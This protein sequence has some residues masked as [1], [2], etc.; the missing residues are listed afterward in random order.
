LSF[1]ARLVGATSPARTVTLTNTGT[2]IEISSIAIAG[3]N[4]ADFTHT[5]NCGATLMSGATCTISVIFKPSAI[6]KRSG[7]LSIQHTG[8]GSPH[9]V[10]LSGD[11][12]V[13]KL[14]PA[15]LNF[16]SQ[17][18]GTASAVQTS[19]LTNTGSTA[20]SISSIVTGGPHP[21]DFVMTHTCPTSLAAGSSCPIIIQFKPPL[22]PG[23]RNAAVS[24][25]H[26]GGG[27]PFTLALSGTGVA[28][29]GPFSFLPPQPG[30]LVEN[31]PYSLTVA[32][33][34]NDGHQ[35]AATA[36]FSSGVSIGLGGGNGG[37][38]LGPHVPT[39][40]APYTITAADFNGDNKVD[41]AVGYLLDDNISI[42]LGN[43]NGTFQLPREFPLGGS[44]H[45]IAVGDFNKDAKP[46][47]ATANFGS[48]S[49]S[50]LLGHGDG[51][52]QPPRNFA[53]GAGPRS[54]AA[55]DFNGDSKLD[56]AVANA[57]SNNVSVLLGNGDGSFQPLRNFAVG[58]SPFSIIARDL[59]GDA[60]VD[61]ATA[62]RGSNTVSV[63]LGNGDGTFRA[64]QNFAV[65]TE[66][67]SMAVAD[68]NKDGRLD[69]ATG[70]QGSNNVSV[71][72]GNG[73]GT[74]ESA[75]NFSWKSPSPMS[76]AVGDFNGDV[77][78]PD[79]AVA[80]GVSAVWIMINNTP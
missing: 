49:V 9:T 11:G 40:A 32:D 56:V 28:P 46:D 2:A 17:P 65:G 12:T 60:K 42:L 38:L 77:T 70:N 55:G 18:V 45:S 69:L 29:A 48:N 14:R 73:D 8:G 76:I 66:P 47:V 39:L 44:A 23:A 35:D 19:T 21:G 37:F 6:G 51:T 58:A 5:H 26:N 79:L 43:G 61:L 62:N 67:R 71:L 10:N 78:R 63:L 68:F 57:D 75:H 34:N 4:P 3:T 33:F 36:D 64:A 27:S 72:A 30:F 54:V 80:D 59:N 16:G 1:V 24:I 74:F 31:Y 15:S 20:V 53:V 13:I 50:V 22:V 7:A 52:F 25:L 41:L